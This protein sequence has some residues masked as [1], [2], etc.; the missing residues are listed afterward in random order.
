VQAFP[1]SQVATYPGSVGLNSTTFA[2]VY[3]HPGFAPWYY[4][5]IQIVVGTVNTVDKT[6]SFATPTFITRVASDSPTYVRIDAFDEY[7]VLVGLGYTNL[8][9][10][11]LWACSIN[12]S[13]LAISL[14]SPINTAAN[15]YQYFS[16]CTLGLYNFIVSYYTATGTEGEVRSGT[17]SGSATI[18]FDAQ[19]AVIFDNG[20]SAYTALCRMTDNYFLLSYKRG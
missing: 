14:G 5:G 17:L 7:H 4:S 9:Y 11:K 3:N 10:V 12:P 13:N 1:G 19:G 8:T 16:L 18:A 6:I 20:A 2:I 15:A